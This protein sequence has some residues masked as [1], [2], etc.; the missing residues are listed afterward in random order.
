MA[1]FNILEN[2][3]RIGRLEGKYCYQYYLCHKWWYYGPAYGTEKECRD[4]LI[5]ILLIEKLME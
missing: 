5:S 4:K 2:K 1:I 3:I